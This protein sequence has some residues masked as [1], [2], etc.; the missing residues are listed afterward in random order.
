MRDEMAHSLYVYKILFNLVDVDSAQFF[1]VIGYNRG[2]TY[3]L[4]TNYCR[5]SV[6]THF[7]CN[8][9]AGMWN[10]LDAAATDFNTLASIVQ[11][12]LDLSQYLS[13]FIDNLCV[14]SIVH[15]YSDN[16]VY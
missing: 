8:R 1:H 7:F 5:V 6:R 4:Y 14:F 2:H 16:A 12:V 11:T 13:F 15:V 10:A 3:E 9:V